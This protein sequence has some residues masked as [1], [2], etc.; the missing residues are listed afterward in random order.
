MR[1]V[2]QA[3]DSGVT[4]VREVPAPMCEPHEVLVGAECSVV[5]AGTE[6]TV[7]ELAKKSLLGKAL[8]RPDHVRR[9][10][11]KLREEGVLETVRQV[12]ARLLDPLALG[13]SCAG[14]VLEC[15]RAVTSLRP[16]DRVSAAGAH[17]EIVSVPETL[18]AKVPDGVAADRSCYAVLV[19]IALNGVRHAQ[20][21]LGDRVVVIGLGL[22]GQI[23]VMLLASSGC[24]VIGT[25][26]DPSRRLRAKELGADVSDREGI[27]AIVAERSGGRGADAVILSA[28]TDSNEPL[29]LA[30][31]VARKRARLVAIGDVRMDVPRRAFYPKELSLIVSCSYGPGRYDARYE[32]KG[33]DFPYD[34]VR[35]TAQRNMQTALEMMAAGLLPVERL[36]THRF[37]I[38]AGESAYRLVN[39]RTEPF[40]GIL[41][42]YPGGRNTSRRVELRPFV[43]AAR[44]EVGVACVGAG[45]FASAVL[46]PILDRAPRTR[47]RL[48]CSAG[49]V[50]AMTRGERHGFEAATTDADAVFEDPGV[51]AVFIATRH[52]THAEQALRALSKGKHVYLEKPLAIT[53]EEL[54]G[55]VESFASLQAPPLLTLGFNRRFSRAAELV[56]AHFASVKAPLLVSHR[57]NALAIP[58]DHWIQDPDRG[59]GRLVGEACHA[60]DFAVFLTGSRIARVVAE[61]IAPG[62]SSGA[63]EDQAT[64]VARL[65]DGAQVT[66]V[67]AAGGD[68]GIPKERIEI[69]GGGRAAVVDDFRTVTLAKGGRGRTYRLG[70]RDKGH[71]AAVLHFLDAVR[72][73][74]P[75][76]IPLSQILN[77]SAAALCA[78]ASLKNGTWETPPY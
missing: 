18:A 71:E 58:E 34:Y 61:S 42:E 29:E 74:G 26:P 3:V 46:L 39:E 38:E 76:P 54:R 48:L 22:L 9:V 41:L 2:L 66:V 24:R 12:R 4:G 53:M 67:Y 30:A 35:W 19:S 51:H 20:V 65:E 62:G 40:L 13:Y 75:V 63:A 50:H 16:G 21:G 70:A 45:N 60:L 56:K 11:Q 23:T 47:K 57:F 28:A 6:R 15:G 25:D 33:E 78:V 59:G 64:I 43:A 77:V 52:D 44:D 27:E 36:T 49:G 32:Q 7:I 68:R 73:G 17:A 10:L 14:V 1:Q 31:A 69:F 55:F 5:S 8:E 37:P 72:A